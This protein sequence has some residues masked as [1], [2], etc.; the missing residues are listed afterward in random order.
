[1]FGRDNQEL[2]FFDVVKAA[3]FQ[4]AM[5]LPTFNRHKVGH[6]P[7]VLPERFQETVLQT[8]LSSGAV[9]AEWLDAFRNQSVSHAFTA[10]PATV[11]YMWAPI[12]DLMVVGGWS[13]LGLLRPPQ[14]QALQR[15]RTA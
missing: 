5:Q 2:I 13:V 3:R 6:S 10:D 7:H 1:M 11:T 12:A 14:K 15:H 8:P 9:V 4:T